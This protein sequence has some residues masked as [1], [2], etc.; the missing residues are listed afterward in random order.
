MS[1]NTDARTVSPITLSSEYKLVEMVFN[2]KLKQFKR[3]N[4][5][6]IDH[7]FARKE[8]KQKVR[9]IIIAKYQ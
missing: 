2:W 6:A 3:C 8:I 9:D 7:S 5:E 4:L 1:L